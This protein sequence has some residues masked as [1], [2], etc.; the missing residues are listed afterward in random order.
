MRKLPDGTVTFLFTDIEGSTKLLHEL[1]AERYARSLAEHRRV[2]RQAFQD[3]RGVEV[4]TQGDAFFVAFG[5]AGEAL[6]AAREAQQAL[7][8]EAIRVRMGLHTGEP[9]LTDEGYVGF[10]VHKA[11]RICSAGHGGQILVS[12]RTKLAVADGEL[13]SLGAHRLKDLTAPEPLYQL[14]EAEFPPLKSLNQSN[15]PVQP[16]P[17]VG[18]EKE[19]GEVLGLLGR[20]DLRLLTL[21]G[22]GGSGK[23]RIAVQAAAEVVEAQEHGVWWVGLQAVQDAALVEPAIASTIGASGD[24]AAHIG[25]KRML[26]LLDNLEQVVEAAPGLA[27]LLASC[28]NLSLLV[29]SRET[30]HL[31][32]EQEYAVP[33]FVEQEAVGFFLARARAVRGD[34]VDDGSVLP[35]CRRLDY[36]PLALELAAA[37]VKALS[38]AQILER[39]EQSLPLLT[40]GPRD[41]P[42]RQRT[43]RGTI[44]WSHDL[45]SPEEQQLFRRLSAFSG[46]CGLVA[47]E[48]VCGA[49]L[50]TLQSLVDKSLLRFDQER[51]SMLETIRE[52][53]VERLD[54]SGEADKVRR[55]HADFFLALA[56]SANMSA[57]GDYGR[58]YDLLL[59]EQDNLRAAVDWLLASGEI[60]L[61]FRF[62][63]ALENFWV[64][65]DPFEGMRRFEALFEAGGDVE[66][67]LRARALRCYGGSS[68]VSGKY[69]QAVRAYEE[70]LALFR[71]QDDEQGVAVLLHRLGVSALVV[72]KSEARELL[73]E[74]LEKFRRTGSR[75]GEGEAIGSLGHLEHAEGNL[76]GALALYEESAAIVAPLG[77]TWWEMNMYGAYAECALELGRISEGVTRARESLALASEIGDRQ[78]IV[79][80]LA[81]LAWGAAAHRDPVRAGRLW[82]ALEA[83]ERRAPVGQWEDEREDYAKRVLEVGAPQFEQAREAGRGLSLES[84]IG[85]AL[86]GA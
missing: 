13:R 30:L 77:F 9:L 4:D 53:A 59:P 73:E 85:E 23:T 52:F 60:E 81:V 2:L 80:A 84:A 24:L 1:G 37:R 31:T 57:E 61:G 72:D 63:V 38:Q 40:G 86:E 47:A 58:R 33:P 16:T 51:Y 74:S 56:E 35:I 41:A 39:L 76:E 75:R 11:A 18:R 19:L 22:P 66:P 3:H 82:G 78:G 50:D 6:A 10:D 25:N 69:E 68:H 14:G 20:H 64:I 67:V 48:E 70:S 8:A 46:G 43:L 5:D 62:T 79:Y 83:E 21:T 49:D 71:A 65:T 12:E 55:R 29:T 17:F 27:G 15:L 54:E 7:A 36:L 26:L 42:E 45:L 28:P 44:E 32:A 34:F